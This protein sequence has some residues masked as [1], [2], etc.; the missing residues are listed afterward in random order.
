M[1]ASDTGTVFKTAVPWYPNLEDYVFEAY[2]AAAVL[3]PHVKL[4]YND[5]SMDGKT[6][7]CHMFLISTQAS[8]ARHIICTS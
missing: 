2:K 1:S 3:R 5:Y 8:T 4:F 7:R 6:E